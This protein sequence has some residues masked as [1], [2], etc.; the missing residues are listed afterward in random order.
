MKKKCKKL[1]I[2]LFIL[3][4]LQLLVIA[5]F[6]LTRLPYVAGFDSS[7]AMAQA[8]QIWKQRTIFLKD[9]AYQSTLG[10]DSGL[11]LASMIYGVTGNIFISYGLSNCVIIALYFYVIYEI[12]KEI[13]VSKTVRLITLIILFT[14][15]SLEPLGYMPMLFTNASYY[16]IKVLIPFMF[17]FIFIKLYKERYLGEY[18]IISC[19]LGIMMYFTAFSCG[20]YVMI[21]GVLPILFY[22]IYYVICS[23]NIQKIISKRL[24]VYG[25]AFC[26]FA[27][28]YITTKWYGQFNFT[29]GMQLCSVYDFGKNLGGFLIGWLQLFGALYGRDLSVFSMEGIYSLV[30]WALIIVFAGVVVRYLRTNSPLRKVYIGNNVS[31]RTHVLGACEFIILVNTGILL[32]TNITYGSDTFEFRYL[33]FSA[34]AIFII[35]AAGLDEY[36]GNMKHNKRKL[37]YNSTWTLI[38]AL[39]V[40]ANAGMIKY[41]EGFEHYDKGKALKESLVDVENIV[42]KKDVNYWYF[43]G[44]GEICEISR[45]MRLSV[46]N[47]EIADGDN[48]YSVRGWGT[49][50]NYEAAATTSK[51]MYLIVTEGD[52]NNIADIESIGAKYVESIAG[53]RIYVK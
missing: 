39:M 36:L 32:L 47:V 3:L 35:L 49:K 20:L 27:L 8:M 34:V 48:I 15:Y 44:D 23:G 53:F 51:D 25:V 24:I 7:A 1:E 45:V 9:W 12:L 38:I 30:H 52:T 21:C 37:L 16:S 14:P 11:L 40:M 26:L 6:N 41:Y 46:K 19:I 31:L 50:S 10:L 17:I 43:V 2:F 4:V 28:G 33:L 5:V 29:N 42:D 13:N 22:E 18:I